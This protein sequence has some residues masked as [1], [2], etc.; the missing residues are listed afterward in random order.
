MTTPEG[1]ALEKPRFTG[2]TVGAAQKAAPARNVLFVCVGN[3]CRSQMAEGFGRYYAPGG[4]VV[5]SAGTNPADLVAPKA[6]DVMKEKGFDITGQY[7][8]PITGRM[9]EEAGLVVT[10]GCEVAGLCPVTLS[11]DKTVDW[12]LEDPMGKG[13]EKYREIRDLVEEKV[14]GLFGA[15]IL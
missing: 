11:P 2:V 15:A 7:P 10:M 3:S 13:I 1:T 9:V 8:K 4:T 6:V 5:R 14:R 12:G